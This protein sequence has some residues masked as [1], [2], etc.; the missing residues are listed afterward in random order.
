MVNGDFFYNQ[1][2]K[3]MEELKKQLI[4]YIHLLIKKDMIEIRLDS[5]GY[6]C[7]LYYNNIINI[8]TMGDDIY[9]VKYNNIEMVVKFTDDE[10]KGISDLINEFTFKNQL[11]TLS[12]AMSQLQNK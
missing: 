8:D 11:A 4:D 2:I 7:S 1:T 3:N 12:E 6:W 9:N 5:S 10:V